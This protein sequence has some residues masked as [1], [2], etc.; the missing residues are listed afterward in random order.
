MTG[1]VSGVVRGIGVDV[2]DIARFA[3]VLERTPHIRERVFHP[4]ELA[5]LATLRDPVR[6]L[7]ARFAV[8][9]AVMKALGVGLGSFDFQDVWVRRADSGA[10]TLQVTGRAA[11]LARARQVSSWQCSLSHS[12]LVAIAFVVA[13]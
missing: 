8:R 12:D 1:L 3:R 4:D 5:D 10:P 7:A 11:S 9:E 6:S 2:V 13:S